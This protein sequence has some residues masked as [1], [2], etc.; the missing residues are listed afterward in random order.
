MKGLPE[1]FVTSIVVSPSNATKAYLTVSGFGS[2]H[3]F[4]T[5]DGGSNWADITF[6]PA[7]FDDM[8]VAPVGYRAMYNSSPPY[9]A[10]SLVV[11]N[12]NQL[13]GVCKR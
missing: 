7:C 11:L 12:G 3:V 13:L 10:M 5:L 6:R 4:R 2:G 1:R 9:F 8:L